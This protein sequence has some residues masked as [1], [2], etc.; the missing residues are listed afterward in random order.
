MNL[1]VKWG[2]DPKVLAGVINVSTGKCWPSEVN[3]PVPGVVE[4]APA[5]RDYKGGFGIGLMKKDLKLAMIAAQE[6]GARL[7]LAQ[8]AKDV[9]EN[10]EGQEK[11]KGR[12]F[13]VVYRYLGGQE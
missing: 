2:L 3:N 12:D 4:T 1:G 6:A 9:Y 7:E 5:G 13:S 8:K 10:A 11:C